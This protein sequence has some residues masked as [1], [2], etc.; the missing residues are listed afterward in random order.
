MPLEEG[1]GS[2]R[3]SGT[4]Y[5]AYGDTE[6]MPSLLNS[7]LWTTPS[8]VKTSKAVLRSTSFVQNLGSTEK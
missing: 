8:L 3:L 2:I 1:N 4:L 5:R 6:S 7:Y